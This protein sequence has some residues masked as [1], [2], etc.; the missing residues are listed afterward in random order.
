M[1]LSCT[2]FEILFFAEYLRRHVTLPTPIWA[3]VGR[4][5]VSSSRSEPVTKFEDCSFNH[6][7]DILWGVKFYKWSRDLGHAPFRDD[8]SSAGWDMQ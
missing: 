7:Q 6:S 2:V 4:V 5:K 8:L 1:S 3:T